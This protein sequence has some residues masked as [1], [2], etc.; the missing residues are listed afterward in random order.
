[1]TGPETGRPEAS[2][3]FLLIHV[4]GPNVYGDLTVSGFST[5]RTATEVGLDFAEALRQRWPDA[6]VTATVGRPSDR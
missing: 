5:E 2:G 1:V 4:D 6:R 3:K